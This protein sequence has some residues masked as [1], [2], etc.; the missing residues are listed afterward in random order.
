MYYEKLVKDRFWRVSRASLLENKPVL[1]LASV[2]ALNY[3]KMP[4]GGQP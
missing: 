3:Y 1:G 2:V 4:L